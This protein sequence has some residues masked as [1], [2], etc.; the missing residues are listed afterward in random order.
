MIAYVYYTRI[1]SK[2]FGMIFA[3][4]IYPLVMI[5]IRL[6]DY[7]EI[8]YYI[9]I[10]FLMN[11]VKFMIR[12]LALISYE[13]WMY[14]KIIVKIFLRIWRFL[15]YM[16]LMVFMTGTVLI[17]FG[18]KPDRGDESSDDSE[19]IGDDYLDLPLEW[20]ILPVYFLVFR[21]FLGDINLPNYDSG[22]EPFKIVILWN[23]LIFMLIIGCIIMTNVLIA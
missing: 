18:Q 22:L 20:N 12:D 3:I 5:V 4:C 13:Y 16:I 6:Y 15:T 9:L 8:K 11:M 2:F 21:N 14:N 19:R 1:W 17:F 7:E 23:S 10:L